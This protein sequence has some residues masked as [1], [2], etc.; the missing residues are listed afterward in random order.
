MNRIGIAFD[1]DGVL[2]KGKFV[3]PE[4]VRAIQRVKAAKVPFVLLTNGGGTTEV[5]KA[6]ELSEKLHTEI[7]SSQYS[8]LLVIR[9]MIL[10]HTPMAH[11]AKKYSQTETESVLIIGK[12]S[13]K[14]A[15]L[16]Y[17]FK[18]PILS[19][20]ILAVCPEVWPFK[21]SVNNYE[22]TNID[23][24][25]GAILSFHDSEDW[26][27]D[28]QIVCDLLRTGGDLRH[29]V[30]PKHHTHRRRHYIGQQ[31]PIYFSNGDFVWSNNLPLTRFAQGSFLH[32]LEGVYSRLSGGSKLK[33]TM[34]GKPHKPTYDFAKHAIDTYAA[35]LYGA[36]ALQDS[37]RLYFGIGDNPES[38][39]E[40][41]NRAGWTSV[42]VKTG[43]YEGGKHEANLL[44]DNV[45]EA[46]LIPT[47]NRK[48]IYQQLFQEGVLVAKKDYNLPK[49]NEVDVPNLH[50][51]KA[52]Q[53]L[54]SRGL[55]HVQFSWQYYY[56]FLNDAGIEYLRKFLHLPTEIVPRTHIKTAKAPGVRPGR[57]ERPRNERR[58]GGDGYRR[59]DDGEKKEGAAGDFRPEFRGGVGRGGPRPAQV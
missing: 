44:V 51:I 50:V 40:G 23:R 20:E 47:E 43:V 30:E 9:K 18:Y 39:I 22:P 5:N 19:G 8:N 42:L 56:Y 15:A 34:Y 21:H 11:L 26:G 37:G 45:E 57:E 46:M 3:L 54:E 14:K 25:V 17:G 24:K 49:H 36:D 58:D 33:Y 29:V 6:R 13:C 7:K 52:L 2:I 27:R 1:I 32:A 38:D 48:K 53:S 35:E 55:V 10:S 41:A 12:D 28:I 31:L 59:R 4:G 16:E